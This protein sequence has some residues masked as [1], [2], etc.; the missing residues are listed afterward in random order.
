MK[1]VMVDR[2]RNEPGFKIGDIPEPATGPGQVKIKVRAGGL[3]RADL[4]RIAGS[5]P[6]APGANADVMGMEF[7]G[8]VV[9]VGDGVDGYKPGDRIMGNGPAAMAEYVVTPAQLTLPAPAN[10]SWAE[11]GAL[12]VVLLTGHNSVVTVGGLQ[13]GEAVLVHAITSGAGM[14]AAQI[15]AEK[16]AAKI[17]GTS[18]SPDK[19]AKLKEL[20]LDF[21]PINHKTDDLAAI[22]M[23]ETNDAGVP[24]VIDQVGASAFDANMRAMSLLGRLVQV[25]RLGGAKAE[26]DLDF[27]ALRRI[28]LIGVTFRTRSVAEKVEI[29]RLCLDDMGEAMAAGRLTPH[30][31]RAFPMAEA[32]AAYAH[33][34][35]NAHVGKIVVEID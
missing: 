3:N 1:A 34:A 14:A 19:M 29:I 22:V 27:L 11:A 12:P 31:D 13:A 20:G 10:L 7:A 30:I 8:E 24:L 9:E 23:Q 2:S 33:L 21:V 5:Y 28:S 32:G 16:G 15:A 4:L 6:S 18:G 25:G 26:I 17:F 35:A